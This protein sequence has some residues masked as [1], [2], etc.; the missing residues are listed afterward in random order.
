[1]SDAKICLKPAAG[2]LRWARETAGMAVANVAARLGVT[3]DTVA[4]WESGERP[5]SIGRLEA[6]A[7]LYRR[8]LAALLLPGPPEAAP[9]P[10]DFRMLPSDE[11]VPLSRETLFAVREARRIQNVAKELAADL[12]Q[13]P[14]VVPPT[15]LGAEPV[16][17]AAREREHIGITISEQMSWRKPSVA[18]KRWREALEKLNVLIL[19][20]SMPVEDARGFSL[21]DDIAPA[22]V[23]NSQDAQSARAFTLFHEYAHLLR[24]SSAMCIPDIGTSASV[25]SEPDEAF[26]NA[27][28]GAFLVPAE[29]LRQALAGG[30]P[31]NAAAERLAT[32]FSVSRHVVLRRLRALGFLSRSAFESKIADTRVAAGQVRPTR[33]GGPAFGG[34]AMRWDKGPAIRPPCPRCKGPRSDHVSRRGG[35]LVAA[36]TAL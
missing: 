22:I 13:P 35:L 14:G 5:L 15:E 18:L 23:L 11:K 21:P 30:T 10:H 19:Q 9:F 12:A 16:G 17:L 1:M 26:C 8:P 33:E 32:E 29:P 36:S 6:L 27:F 28:A 31:D 34:A 2:V 3:S 24:G 25:A 20:F 4:R 7:H